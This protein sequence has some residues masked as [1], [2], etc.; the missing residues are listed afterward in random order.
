MEGRCSIAD[1]TARAVSSNHVEYISRRRRRLILLLN[2]HMTH[3][4]DICIKDRFTRRSISKHGRARPYVRN[5]TFHT[6][7]HVHSKA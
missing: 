1:N 6:Y 3:V 5:G 7:I 2:M 4:M